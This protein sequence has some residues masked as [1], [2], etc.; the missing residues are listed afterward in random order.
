MGLIEKV[1]K[2]KRLQRISG[3]LAMLIPDLWIRAKGWTQQTEF[4]MEF[5]PGSDQIV[6]TAKGGKVGFKEGMVHKGPEFKS[7]TKESMTHKSGEKDGECK[8]CGGNGCEACSAQHL[9]GKEISEPVT[10]ID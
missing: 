5:L 7:I 6:I 9:D 10:T 4:M 1:V 8:H 3:S 2:S